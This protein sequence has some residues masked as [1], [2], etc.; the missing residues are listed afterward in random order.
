MRWQKHK[1]RKQ[2]YRRQ[3][4]KSIKIKINNYLVDM[5]SHIIKLN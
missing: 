3:N 1:V 4:N 5:N 2:I